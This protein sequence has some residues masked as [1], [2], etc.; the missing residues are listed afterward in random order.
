M[1]R[2]YDQRLPNFRHIS[3]LQTAKYWTYNLS[4]WSHCT[5]LHDLYL[6]KF[7]LFKSLQRWC[8]FCPEFVKWPVQP[9]YFHSLY[10]HL[11][12]FRMRVYLSL[13]RTYL[14]GLLSIFE[15]M[16]N[17]QREMKSAQV[18]SYAFFKWAIPAFY[19]L[20]SSFQTNNFYNK[21]MWKISIQYSVVGFEHS[22]F[23]TRVS[24]HNH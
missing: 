11:S 17:S 19:C 16:W 12:S 24:S 20:F 10:V 22:T 18:V 1:T 4:I 5:Y 14:I 13:L 9:T 3:L 6:R 8:C 7:H 15:W 23:R 21:Y 2:W